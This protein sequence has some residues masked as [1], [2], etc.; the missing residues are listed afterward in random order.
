MRWLSLFNTMGGWMSTAQLSVG[1][2]IQEVR[3]ALE[4]DSFV[5][6]AGRGR[7]ENSRQRY[8]TQRSWIFD[9]KFAQYSN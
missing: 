6:T 7:P 9:W 5:L 4:F 2:K 3:D 1:P 8:E